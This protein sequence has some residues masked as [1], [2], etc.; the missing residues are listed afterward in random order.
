M[1]IRVCFGMDLD[2]KFILH[3]AKVCKTSLQI[4]TQH[5]L[6]DDAKGSFCLFPLFSVVVIDAEVLKSG[7]AFEHLLLLF[8]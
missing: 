1:C 2:F 7:L 3:K 8:I 4:M 5:D 6:G